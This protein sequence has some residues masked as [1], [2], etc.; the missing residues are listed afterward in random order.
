MDSA[1]KIMPDGSSKI[2]LALKH[3][4][5][6]ESKMKKR[7]KPIMDEFIMD[8]HGNHGHKSHYKIE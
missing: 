1:R 6:V 4:L 2:M 7:K 8:N 3:L 5:E